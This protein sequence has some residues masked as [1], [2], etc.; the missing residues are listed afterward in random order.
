M[1][2]LVIRSDRVVTPAGVAACDVAIEGEKIAAV[3]AA[4]T[5][6]ADRTPAARSTPPGRS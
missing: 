1:F 2:D 5:F 3:A 6:G 4:G